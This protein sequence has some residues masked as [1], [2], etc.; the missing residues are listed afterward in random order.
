MLLN[1]IIAVFVNGRCLISFQI[2]NIIEK[3]LQLWGEKKACCI[4]SSIF[5]MA[6]LF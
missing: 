5:S 3:F 2:L 4:I 6:L 1:Y